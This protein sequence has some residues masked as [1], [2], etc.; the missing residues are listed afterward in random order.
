MDHK[1]KLT[2][3][4]LCSGNGADSSIY[5]P[6][7][8]D[9][10]YRHRQDALVRCVAST[11]FSAAGA[12]TYGSC[13]LILLY[14]GDLSCM[15][16]KLSSGI[17]RCGG[18]EVQQQVMAPTP[19]EKDIVKSWKIAANEATRQQHHH[20]QKQSSSLIGTMGISS[21]TRVAQ[22]NNSN[23]DTTL[24]LQ[25]TCVLNSWRELNQAK[26]NHTDTASSKC[27][28]K[29]K[30]ITKL[31]VHMPASKRD[32][33]CILQ[34]SCSLEFLRSHRLNAPLDV[35]LKKFNKSKV[36]VVWDA[37]KKAAKKEEEGKNSVS[38][39]KRNSRT[40]QPEDDKRIEGIFLNILAQ[41]K[42]DD[43]T[44]NDYSTDVV[45]AYLHESCDAELP[46]WSNNDQLCNRY[47]EVKH[48]FL[49]CG[50]VRDMTEKENEFL[51]SSCNKLKIPLLPCRLGEVAEF[52]S[53]IV[54]VAGHHFYKGVLGPGLIKLWERKRKQMSLIQDE[55]SSPSQPLDNNNSQKRSLHTIAIIPM[56]SSLLA[57]DPSKRCRIHWCMVRLCVCA[58]YRSK[59]ASTL[60]TRKALDNKLSFV[61]EDMRTLTLDQH[62]FITSLAE[63]HQAA[64]SERQI[65][66][67][68]CRRRDDVL[69]QEGK[70]DVN[71]LIAAYTSNQGDVYALDFT[72]KE[73]KSH[74]ALNQV[75]ELAYSED[76]PSDNTTTEG[77]STLIAILQ[78]RD[79]NAS[80]TN[81]ISHKAILD[82]IA[83]SN[84]QVRTQA[85]LVCEA[86]DGEALTVIMLQ[87][88]DYQRKL[89]GLLQQV[90]E[91]SSTA[92]GSSKAK[93]PNTTESGR[94]RKKKHKDGKKKKKKS[95]KVHHK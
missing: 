64:P 18:E 9:K 36:Q 85:P 32:A 57:A 22:N 71:E 15:K 39:D 30:H 77:E 6:N 10:R 28:T 80:T 26:I 46:C 53:K 68:L 21:L 37:A 65:L 76:C 11:L 50:A 91:E 73:D 45:A 74:L 70:D 4:L 66:E 94:K 88:L 38:D 60:S 89:L 27:N 51:S 5:R 61:F 3:V 8:D 42:G 84:I 35:A 17:M 72:N 24:H 7:G 78:V 40:Q 47:K 13:E 52:T 1:Q 75:M 81:S 56:H 23:S 69:L 2:F 79:Q 67:E 33:I 25:T 20:Q 43:I 83:I 12:S 90:F 58:L 19:L 87:H 44:T 16:M 14:D 55:K 95:K 92:E 62:G 63:K 59:L 34:R 41:A 86:Q 48:I 31:P 54:S 93:V 49:F 82:A 29:N